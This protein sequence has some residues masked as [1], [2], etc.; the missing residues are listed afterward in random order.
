MPSP[1]V[2]LICLLML[3]TPLQALA[4][5][6]MHLSA[7]LPVNSSLH[8]PSL[9]SVEASAEHCHDPVPADHQP[10]GGSAC[11]HCTACMSASAI[12]RPLAAP[13]MPL[14]I[15]LSPAQ[16]AVPLAVIAD[17]PERPPR[18]ILA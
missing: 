1:R 7:A 4:G 16:P 13:G 12:G 9:P 3:T 2:L 8:T 11:S 14:A 18:L 5:L 15:F 10:V 17:T 6:S